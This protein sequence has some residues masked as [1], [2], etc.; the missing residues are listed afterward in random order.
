MLKKNGGK[1]LFFEKLVRRRREKRQKKSFPQAGLEP[2]IFVLLSHCLDPYANE[3]LVRMLSQL[4][5]YKLGAKCFSPI[6]SPL[7]RFWLPTF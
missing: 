1:V 4:Y 3:P 7:G 2:A 5:I 6:L